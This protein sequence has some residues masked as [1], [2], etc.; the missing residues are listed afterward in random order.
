M[1]FSV[2]Y[3]A[4]LTIASLLG[5]LFLYRIAT[6][7]TK[8]SIS[9]PSELVQALTLI[10]QSALLWTPPKEG[11][12]SY[13]QAPMFLVS[14]QNGFL[15]FKKISTSLP[16]FFS[17]LEEILMKLP[18]L[19]K[20]SSPDALKNAVQK[21]PILQVDNVTKDSSLFHALLRDF[22]IL[23]SA[24]II[25]GKI[26]AGKP[27]TV[28]P[29]QI[30]EPLFLLSKSADLPPIME[31][32]SYCLGNS[33]SNSPLT[34][35]WDS[36]SLVRAFDGGAGE[37]TFIIIHAEIESRCGELILS[38]AKLFSTL[39]KAYD[40]PSESLNEALV[41]E[42]LSRIKTVTDKIIVSQLKMFNA[43]NPKD[44]ITLVRP[45]IFGWNN[46]N[47]DFPDGVSF[48]FAGG[49]SVQT[50][51]RGETGAQSTIVP[52]LDVVLD[53]HH[54]QDELRVM[55]KE[56]EAYRPTPHRDF[57]HQLRS[58]CYGPSAV[59]SIAPSSP[60]LLRYFVNQ[61]LNNS[62]LVRAFNDCI[63]NVWAFRAIHVVFAEAYITKFTDLKA[64]TGG[65]P[66][67]QYLAKHRTESGTAMIIGRDG[68]SSQPVF[69]KPSEEEA[70]ADLEAIFS[71]NEAQGI[72]K[73]LLRRHEDIISMH[74][75]SGG[76]RLKGLECKCFPE[77]W[78][79]YE[80]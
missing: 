66:Y 7:L 31:Y 44:Y 9:Y 24:Y 21:L 74:G 53:I 39:R 71:N 58:I 52:S 35:N 50:K 8:K 20:D 73:Y 78:P 22:S 5:A 63:G 48:N 13:N 79:Q 55:L 76:V 80:V 41:I 70:K 60:H 57:L 72:P 43:C 19:L 77:V 26:K 42:A 25:E 23:S 6:P 18:L 14:H 61:N 59:E 1:D 3:A 11:S 51:L 2:T 32:S 15:P 54:S 37:A 36:F 64:A 56:L 69:Y 33:V 17:Q 4:S 75:T 12:E 47:A 65:T 10:P 38:Y 45:W 68:G 28:V 49:D 62:R 67:K 30:S 27:R 40:G 16:S 46:A 34:K 29:P